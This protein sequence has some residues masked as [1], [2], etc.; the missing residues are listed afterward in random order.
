MRI[1]DE[2]ISFPKSPTFW[3]FFFRKINFFCCLFCYLI[4]VH[5]LLPTFKEICILKR[6]LQYWSAKGIKKILHCLSTKWAKATP[7]L[8]CLDFSGNYVIQWAKKPYQRKKNVLFRSITLFWAL[9]KPCYLENRVVR[10]PCKRRSACIWRIFEYEN[11]FQIRIKKNCFIIQA[12]LCLR[13]SL[14]T[15]FSK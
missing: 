8:I 2:T 3:D 6:K 12:L 7:F 15:R 1:V 13:G 4:H 14:T 10:E 11:F 5:H 9:K